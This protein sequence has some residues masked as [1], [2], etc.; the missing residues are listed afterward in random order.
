ML[1]KL[2]LQYGVEEELRSFYFPFPEFVINIK[3]LIDLESTANHHDFVDPGA[4][5]SYLCDLS[6]KLTS[7][8]RLHIKVMIAGEPTMT[9][10]SRIWE[11]EAV[12]ELDK[13]LV[14]LQQ[15]GPGME[16]HVP[17]SV[18]PRNH[19]IFESILFTKK[20]SSA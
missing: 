13:L 5:L 16:Y 10:C 17:Q 19:N 7:L 2:V 6:L 8:K 3:T 4:S 18:A 11:H 1:T 9:M 12:R 14:S 15:E 20:I